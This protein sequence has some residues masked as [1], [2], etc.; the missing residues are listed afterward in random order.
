MDIAPAGAACWFF[1]RPASKG[2]VT[3]AK[4]S[5]LILAEIPEE[6]YRPVVHVAR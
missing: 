3:F 1:P 5:H 6:A 2:E 4:A